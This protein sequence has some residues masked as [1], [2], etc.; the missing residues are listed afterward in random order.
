[1]LDPIR[2]P[3]TSVLGAPGDSITERDHLDL[4]S[5]VA[6]GGEHGLE[7]GVD[8]DVILTNTGEAVLLTGIVHATAMGGC[9]RCLDPVEYD[10]AGEVE[11]YF[12]FDGGVTEVE[13]MDSDEFDYVDADGS[14]DIAPAI[15]AALVFD[16][17]YILL[18]DPDCKGLC[19][20]CGTNLNEGPCSCELPDDSDDDAGDNPFAVLRDLFPG[21]GE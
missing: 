21:D 11:G 19:P 15:E 6:G 2:I 20:Q 8:Y 13:D 9:A 3:V 7:D 10:I 1:M 4:R 17:P 5:Y 16:T 18:C 12:L 14:V